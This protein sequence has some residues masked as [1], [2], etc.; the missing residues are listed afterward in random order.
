MIDGI[1]SKQLRVLPDERGRLVEMLRCD[2]ELFQKF[3]QVYMTTTYPHVIK[4]WHYH[5]LQYDNFVCIK[6]MVKLVCFDAREGSKTKGE[7]NEFFVGENNMI[8]LQIPPMVYH[9]WKCISETESMVINV[10]TELYNYKNPDE[11]RL[12]FDSPEI[13]YDWSIKMG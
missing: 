11:F 7:V 2:D 5:K 4:A 8:L 1:K 10:V 9:G 6:G 3:G 13:P 12:P